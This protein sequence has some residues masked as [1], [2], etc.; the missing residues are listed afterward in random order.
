M[1]ILVIGEREHLEECRLKFGKTHTYEFTTGHQA[2]E[3]YFANSNVIFDF[4]IDES[5][6]QMEIYRDHPNAIGFLNTTKISLL[7]LVSAFGG[8]S[9]RCTLFGFNGLPTFLNRDT[10]E[11]TLYGGDSEKLS[12]ICSQLGTKFLVVDD[13][14]GMVTP[15]VICMIINEAYFTLQEGTASREDID[16]GMKLGTNYPLGPF[17]WCSKI[18]IR[19]VFE[20]LEAVYEDTKDERYRICPLLK[21][22]YFNA[23]TAT[24]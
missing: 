18:G 19:H 22:E 10:L 6:E 15:R 21:K 11:V 4:L 16:I 8:G 20:L 17:E 7:E 14:V 3:K 9:I 1:N 5:P 12:L 24:K 2:A 23:I 13:R